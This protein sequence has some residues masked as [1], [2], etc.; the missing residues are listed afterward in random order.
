[1]NVH[2]IRVFLF[3]LLLQGVAGTFG[4]SDSNNTPK[5]VA[6]VGYKIDADREDI[7]ADQD[8]REDEDQ[9]V[10]QVV[11]LPRTIELAPSGVVHASVKGYDSSGIEMELEA[12]QVVWQ[13]EDPQ[14][15]TVDQNGNITGVQTGTTQLLVS[16][17]EVVDSVEVHVKPVDRIEIIPDGGEVALGTPLQLELRAYSED[18]A[19]LSIGTQGIW[20]SDP[21]EIAEVDSNGVLNSQNPGMIEVQ[22][23]LGDMQAQAEFRVEVKFESLH[24][25]GTFC[26]MT[27]TQSDMYCWGQM[28]SGSGNNSGMF[29]MRSAVT[30]IETDLEFISYDWEGLAGWGVLCGLTETGAAY[31][32]GTNFFRMVG[33]EDYLAT[34][35]IPQEL[36]TDLRFQDIALGLGAACGLTFDGDLY[37]WGAKPFYGMGTN[38]V[39]Q[40]NASAEPYLVAEGPF[41]EFR[42]SSRVICLRGLDSR[43]SCIGN[44]LFGLIGD[45]GSGVSHLISLNG[46]EP[47]VDVWPPSSPSGATYCGLN[48]KNRVYCWGS[49]L[50]QTLG[51]PPA[52]DGS[53]LI[54]ETP[55]PTQWDLKISDLRGNRHATRYC[56][57]NMGATGIVCW[58][59]NFSSGSHGCG[60][61]PSVSSALESSYL[62]QHIDGLPE[63]IID[64]S[65]TDSG[66]CALTEGGDIWCWGLYGD[67]SLIRED[68]FDFCEQSP[69]RISTF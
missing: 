33:K 19:R 47:L 48:S 63:D 9:R 2:S 10:V 24:C 37:C 44:D 53:V 22:A 14:V 67:G 27:S 20:T 42:M 21:H 52:A 15:A 50:Y 49:N 36:E 5:D 4:C 65:L 12:G 64:F 60:L 68:T 54:T 8:I 58:G 28:G 1:M 66:G 39:S 16:V 45:D 35:E 13:V 61:G 57:F 26:C 18:G 43:W 17:Q 31:C 29:F 55:Q 3:V 41:T 40:E 23:S 38:E 32:W 56:G 11:L 59:M 25:K 34:Y 51:H 69:Q 62:P 46:P 30:K 6:D 7:T